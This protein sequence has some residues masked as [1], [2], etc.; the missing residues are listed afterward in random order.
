MH[1]SHGL[2]TAVTPENSNTSI[3]NVCGFF[4]ASNGKTWSLT[5]KSSHEQASLAFTLSC[6]KLKWDGQA[7]WHGCLMTACQNSSYMV[8][9]AMANDQLGG[10]GGGQK[11]RFKDTLKKTL[12]SFNIDV[13]NWEVCAQ[14][15]PLWRSMI[16]T[17]ART[18]ETI[19]IAEAQKK[20]AARKA[21]L[22]HFTTLP[23]AFQPARHT[24][25]PSVE[26]CW[27]IRHLHTHRVNQT[28]HHHHQRSYG[29]HRKRW[30]NNKFSL[31]MG[32]VYYKYYTS[33]FPFPTS[34]LLE[35]V[36]LDCQ[37]VE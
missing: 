34:I 15:R 22:Y 29:H 17:G 36:V 13:T 4:W 37:C 30:T 21:R 18:A 11:K 6:R 24:H 16:H 3:Q 27:L 23:P 33:T 5:Q 12:T 19:R 26:E 1:V 31:W 35:Y 9:C 2:C 32:K 7:T 28:W 14:D 25:A 8:S 10:E 20:C